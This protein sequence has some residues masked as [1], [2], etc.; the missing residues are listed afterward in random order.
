MSDLQTKDWQLEQ[1][2]VNSVVAEIEKKL[3]KLTR[4]AG[5]VG[6][7]VLEI[8]KSFWEDVT[9]NLDE[10]DDIIET[11]ASIKQQAEF[12]SERERTHRQHDQQLKTLEKLKNSPYFGRID[13]F[14]EG[15]KAT[16]KV[17]L[18]IASFMDEHDENFLIYDW[19][20]PISSLYYDYSPGPAHYETLEGTIKGEMELKRQFIIRA[21]EIKGMFDTGVTIGDEMLQEVLG[22]NAS[23]QMKSIVATIQRE[24]NAI[25]RNERSKLLIVQ[26]VAGSGKTSAA[27]QRVAYLLYRYRGTLNSENIMLFS[28]NPLFNSYVATVLPELGEENMRQSTFQEYLNHRLAREFEVEDPFAQ[29]EYLLSAPRDGEYDTRVTGIRFKASLD[30]K[31]V[32]DDFAAALSNSGLLFKNL[33]FR[34]NVLISNREI[35]DYFYA[36]DKNI[37]MP[38]RIQLVQEWLLKELKKWVKRERSRSWVE[39]E[40][41][42]LEKEDYME[43]FKKLQQKSRFSENTFDDYEREQQLLAQMV[44]KERFKPLFAAVKG[45]KFIDMPEI[46]LTLLETTGELKSSLPSEWEKISRQ[47]KEKINE[48]VI[49]YEDATPYVYLQDLIE[50]RKSNT[51]IRHIFID[52]AQDY[53]PLQFA[54]IQRLFPYSKMTLLGDFNQAIYSGATGAGTVLTES[55]TEEKDVDTFVLTKTYRSTKE[56]VKF[57]KELVPGGGV[58]EPFNR[59]GAK[60]TVMFAERNTLDRRIINKINELQQ[61]GYRTIAVICRT[62]AESRLAFE[63]L[64]HEVSLHLIEKGTVSY[65]KGILVIPSYLAKGIEFDAVILYDS[66]QYRT[67]SE[68]KL[69]YTVCTRAMHELHMFATDGLSPL[70]LNVPDSTFEVAK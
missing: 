29:I 48:M 22:N 35:H 10:P 9:V 7:D 4:N 12:L 63:A 47:T 53:T 14:E 44:V 21:S 28:P 62:E 5:K 18:G 43:A 1:E 42:Y 45:L 65:E 39:E 33:R 25:I 11:Y 50:G 67:E 24:Q 19:R 8:R 68:R 58:I 38:N 34:G 16:D 15:E 49:P 64:K 46:Y 27:L 26:G 13:F 54:F 40:I 57:T 61:Q 30:F 56:I 69:F 52:E 2:R 23:T 31:K 37:S 55:T 70:M 20:A 6:A 41:Q 32:I 17:Y 51:A 60:P 59:S 3:E 36:L 66:S